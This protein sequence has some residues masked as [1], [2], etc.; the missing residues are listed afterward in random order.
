MIN[1]NVTVKVLILLANV[2]FIVSWAISFGVSTLTYKRVSQVCTIM[3]SQFVFFLFLINWVKSG[4]EPFGNM[5]H[6]MIFLALCLPTVYLLFS[7]FFKKAWIAPYVAFVMIWVLLGAF[8][9]QDLEWRKPPALQ[10]PW[11]LPHVIAYMISYALAAVAFCITAKCWGHAWCVRF[12]SAKAGPDIVRYQAA[13][14]QLLRLAFPLMTFGMLSGAL[15]AE[16]AWGVY[17]SWDRKEVFSL[18]TWTLYVI[19]FHSLATPR[20]RK[21]ADI[22]QVLAFLALLAT[23]L[24]VNLLPKLASALHSYA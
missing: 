16:E 6:V 4:G 10:S 13:S 11:F 18:I 9:M 19:Y 7:R 3:G 2:C 14:R 21:Y 23:F 15:W 8:F 17:W 5:Y 1:L 20:L 12:F 22:P 24:L